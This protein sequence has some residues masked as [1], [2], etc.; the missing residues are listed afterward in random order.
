MILKYSLI[1]AILLAT[2]SANYY[3]SDDFIDEINE[4]ADT[5]EAGRNF[6]PDVSM[7][8]VKKMLGLKTGPIDM[9][10]DTQKYDEEELQDLPESFDAR[11]AWPECETI[12]EIRDQGCE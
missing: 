9:K 2:V 1:Q 3:L 6:Q 5:W 10:I 7:S 11:E 8:D 4:K 12:K